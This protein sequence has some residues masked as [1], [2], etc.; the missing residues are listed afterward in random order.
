MRML[1]ALFRMDIH[2]AAVV[3]DMVKPDD[4]LISQERS[5]LL[6]LVHVVLLPSNLGNI[7]LAL[8]AFE[9]VKNML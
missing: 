7:I 5:K 4:K 9:P 6:A 8:H 2:F 3:E 1:R